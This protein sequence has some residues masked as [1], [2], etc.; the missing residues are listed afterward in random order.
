[1]K[2]SDK[3]SRKLEDDGSWHYCFGSD[4]GDGGGEDLMWIVN[5]DQ[6]WL[7]NISWLTPCRLHHDNGDGG[8]MEAAA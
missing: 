4:G 8:T 2:T 5:A 6:Q 3:I 7:S 1:M